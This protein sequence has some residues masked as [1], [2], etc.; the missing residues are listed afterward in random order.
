MLNMLR[1]LLVGCCIS[2][3]S[4]IW[5]GSD[6]RV[7]ESVQL[8]AGDVV[9]ELTPTKSRFAVGDNPAVWVM[10][11]NLSGETITLPGSLDGSE[12]Q[13]RYPHAFFEIVGPEGG[14]E[15]PRLAYCGNKNALRATDFVRLRPGEAFDPYGHVDGGGFFG[16]DE[17]DGTVLMRPGE[18]EVVFHYST[19]EPVVAGWRGSE[20][21][22]PRGVLEQLRH[23]PRVVVS[24]STTLVVAGP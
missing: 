7:G 24:C 3:A 19:D 5:A 17:F 16:A 2:G 4:T 10:I 13:A 8:E 12:R 20:F 11:R 23:V 22:L 18:Y 14:V 1:V 9:C 15:K 21:A 6:V